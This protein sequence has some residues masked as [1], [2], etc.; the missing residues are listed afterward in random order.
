MD[1]RQHNDFQ[2][3]SGVVLAQKA[4]VHLGATLHRYKKLGVLLVPRVGLRLLLLA[5]VPRA[6]G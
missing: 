5:L 3:F 1:S 2:F 6:A 4:E